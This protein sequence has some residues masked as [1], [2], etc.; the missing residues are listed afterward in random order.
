M[1]ITEGIEILGVWLDKFFEIMNVTFTIWGYSF[2]LWNILVYTV[3]IDGVATIIWNA[4][5]DDEV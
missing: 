5:N 1:S 4:I 2:T 3:V